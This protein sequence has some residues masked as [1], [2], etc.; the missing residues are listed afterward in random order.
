[1]YRQ[2]F[3][4]AFPKDVKFFHK[5]KNKGELPKN[6]KGTDVLLVVAAAMNFCPDKRRK[7]AQNDG[8]FGMPEKSYF[9]AELQIC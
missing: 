8:L 4:D 6:T 3:Y 7:A 9:T 1:M 2:V 5:D